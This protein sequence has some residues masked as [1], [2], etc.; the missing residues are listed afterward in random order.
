[1]ELTRR[2]TLKGMAGAALLGLVAVVPEFTS[3]SVPSSDDVETNEVLV[4]VLGGDGQVLDSV[5]A[6]ALQTGNR[7]E[8]RLSHSAQKPEIVTG[9][10]RSFSPWKIT[11]S[12]DRPV[13]M[14]AGDTLRV[15]WNI[16]VVDVA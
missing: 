10:Q 13:H 7:V 8:L 11:T 4:E 14:K 9:V 16:D 2:A 5:E 15:H 6:H 1:M 3:P 12:F